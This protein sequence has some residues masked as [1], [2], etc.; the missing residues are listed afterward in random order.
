MNTRYDLS[1]LRF[2]RLIPGTALALSLLLTACGTS[3][4]SRF[5]ALPNALNTAPGTS[6]DVARSE[7]QVGFYPVKISPYLDRPQIVSVRGGGEVVVDEF[8]RWAAP[9]DQAV[10]G[11]VAAN[12]AMEL[13]D[14]YIDL[15]PWTVSDPFEYKIMVDVLR[16]DGVQGEKAI[17]IAQ[18]TILS[19]GEEHPPLVRRTSTYESAL[20]DSGYPAYVAGLGDLLQQLTRD[21][22]GVLRE[23]MSAEK[24]PDVTSP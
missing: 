1:L 5:Y 7:I 22:A 19:S 17:L 12:L 3:N 2:N 6:V 4:P 9:L 13:P 11:A 14:A 18:W 8:N 21:M 23:N 15:F 24:A 10:L 20:A 16:L